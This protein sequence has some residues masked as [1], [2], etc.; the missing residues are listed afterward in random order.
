MQSLAIA[1]GS[2]GEPCVFVSWVPGQQGGRA[3]TSAKGTRDGAKPVR[4]ASI[5]QRAYPYVRNARTFDG[6]STA[7]L[8]V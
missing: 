5:A 4:P 6:I 1:S 7:L 3:T 8:A 2:G